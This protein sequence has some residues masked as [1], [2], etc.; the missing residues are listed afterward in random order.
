VVF[1]K[2]K[3]EG[4][5]LIAL[6][7]IADERGFFA[8]SWCAREFEEHGLGTSFVQENVGFNARKG[9]LRGLHFQDP[10]HAEAKLVRC[11][12]GAVWDLALDLRPQ[13]PTFCQWIAAE[14]SADNRTM[15]HIAEGCAHGYLSLTDG[16]EIRYLTSQFY[17][18][19]SA[20]GVRYDDPA[21]AIEWPATIE[22]VS[23]QDSSWPLLESVHARADFE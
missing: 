11:T 6:E 3:L 17:A 12:R 14:L 21:F 2:T 13:S 10:P 18:P 4:V 22:L 7:Q 20:R 15:L 5:F 16:A 23:Q 1:R 8:R 19:E 9:T